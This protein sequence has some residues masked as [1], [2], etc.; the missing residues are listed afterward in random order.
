MAA[1]KSALSFL[2]IVEFGIN[3]NH[4][5][6]N[7]GSDYIGE[8]SEVVLIGQV[9]AITTALTATKYLRCRIQ[10]SDTG[11]SGT[12]AKADE[13]DI[14]GGPGNSDLFRIN[15]AHTSATAH[16]ASYK[17]HKPY[18]RLYMDFV[19][20]VNEDFPF[21]GF[22]IGTKRDTPDTLDIDA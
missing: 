15:S 2:E 11:K 8:F 21:V 6:Q 9:G 19:G 4:T 16:L 5:D 7:I 12:W 18:L 17:G 14:E 10:V 3:N 13:D 22:V 1:K 20:A